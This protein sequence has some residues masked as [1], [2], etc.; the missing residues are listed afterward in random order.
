MFYTLSP[1]LML[2]RYQKLF[3]N[4]FFFVLENVFDTAVD[5]VVIVAF[6]GPIYHQHSWFTS[7]DVGVCVI[8]LIDL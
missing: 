1:E 8:I 2:N 6:I 4:N 5:V 7:F 3:R